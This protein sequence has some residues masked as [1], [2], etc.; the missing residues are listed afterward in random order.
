MKELD[1][2]DVYYYSVE[3]DCMGKV[4]LHG[5]FETLQRISFEQEV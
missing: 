2:N 5:F 1:M 3:G 4:D